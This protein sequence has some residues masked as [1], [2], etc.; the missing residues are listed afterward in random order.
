[1][2]TSYTLRRIEESDIPFLYELFHDSEVTKLMSHSFQTENDAR[3]YLSSSLESMKKA[4]N[5]AR[6][7]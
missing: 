5:Q 4:A 2:E 7:M 3:E 1:M 6:S